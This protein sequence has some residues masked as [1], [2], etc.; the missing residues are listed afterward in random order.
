MSNGNN[1]NGHN[2]ILRGNSDSLIT[3]IGKIVSHQ[4]QSFKEKNNA[5]NEDTAQVLQCINLFNAHLKVVR[6]EA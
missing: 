3:V 2:Q 4:S 1:L 6:E 5:G